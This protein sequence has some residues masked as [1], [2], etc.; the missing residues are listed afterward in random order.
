MKETNKE[1]KR[2]SQKARKERKRE[3]QREGKRERNKAKERKERDK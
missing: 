2:E 1:G 3:T